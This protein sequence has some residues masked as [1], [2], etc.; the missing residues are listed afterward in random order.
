M[1]KIGIFGGTFNPPHIG[2]VRAAESF[3][4]ALALD[5]LLI[6]PD[7]LPP[8]KS[9]SGNAS[10]EDRLNMCRLAFSHIDGAVI[11]DM[12]IKRGGKSY[13]ALTLNELSSPGCELYFLCGTDMFLTLEEWYHPEE[14]FRLANICVVRRES[15]ESITEAI[16]EHR[17]LYVEKYGAKIIL[18]DSETLEISSTDLRNELKNSNSA[19][20]YL[21]KNVNNYILEK[22]LYK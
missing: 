14:I 2:H 6:I 20:K 22:G 1:K 8:H 19:N 10:A 13:T 7:F 15:D 16:E 18:I 12:E 4:R 9:L 5:E 11:S 21:S 3:R 17:K